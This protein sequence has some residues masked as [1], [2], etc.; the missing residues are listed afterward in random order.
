MSYIYSRKC[1]FVFMIYSVFLLMN[2]FLYAQE[3]VSKN[4]SNTFK[5]G[6]YV[7]AEMGVGW[8]QLS[9]DIQD[10]SRDGRFI[11][12]FYGGYRPLYLFRAGIKIDGYLIEAGDNS[13]PEKGIG[14]SN[15]SFQIQVFPFKTIAL[16]SNFQYGW[17]TYEN[18]HIH[19]HNANGT[20]QKIGLGYEYDLNRHFALSAITNYGF[21]KFNDVNDVLVS[22]HDQKYD[23]WDVTLC[24]TYH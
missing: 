18:M 12:G 17:S 11:M 4:D 6:F 1:V 2:T 22:V 16:F 15:T 3:S 21:G 8:L 10:G 19:G 23:S 20:S 5:K 24:L 14:I 13:H 9:S 7:G